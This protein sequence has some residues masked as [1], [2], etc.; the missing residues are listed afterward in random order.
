MLEWLWGLF[1]PVALWVLDKAFG[2][3]VSDFLRAFLRRRLNLQRVTMP[4]DKIAFAQSQGILEGDFPRSLQYPPEW[5]KEWIEGPSGGPWEN[6]YIVARNRKDHRA[7]GVLLATIY[8]GSPTRCIVTYMVVSPEMESET[9]VMWGEMW[10]ALLGTVYSR[11]GNERCEYY[12]MFLPTD[13]S[14]DKDENGRRLR[15]QDL[16]K[17]TGARMFNVD[18]IIPDVTRV[19]DR[20]ALL[21]HRTDLRARLGYVGNATP[22]AVP[23][24]DAVLDFIYADYWWTLQW[25]VIDMVE[26]AQLVT[27]LTDLQTAVKGRLVGSA[28]DLV[29]IA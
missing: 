18:F 1:V 4:V 20:E 27:Y 13:P 25:G 8:Q 9:S 24:F 23:L 26:A 11:T 15:H 2:G 22:R 19:R 14:V 5:V 10:T 17:T 6:V 12:A 3:R 21:S 16:L 28:A 29:D 7:G